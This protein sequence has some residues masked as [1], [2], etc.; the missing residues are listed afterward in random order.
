MV[1]RIEPEGAEIG[2]RQDTGLV[3]IEERGLARLRV[4][5]PEEEANETKSKADAVLRAIAMSN[6]GLDDDG[7]KI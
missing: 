5:I 7:S 4:G 3:E 6:L 2:Q 1:V